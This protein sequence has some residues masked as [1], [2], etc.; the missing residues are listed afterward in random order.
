MVFTEETN[1][2]GRTRVP[3]RVGEGSN[4]VMHCGRLSGKGGCSDVTYDH[5]LALVSGAGSGENRVWS[6]RTVNAACG[7]L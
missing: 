6:K 1:R 2:D 3:C 4:G 7:G 5:V